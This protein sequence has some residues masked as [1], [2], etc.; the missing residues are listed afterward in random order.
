[1]IPLQPELQVRGQNA[2]KSLGLGIWVR[3]LRHD[4]HLWADQFKEPDTN[5]KSLVS[6]LFFFFMGGGVGV[7]FFISFNPSFSA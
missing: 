4:L 6:R 1:M 2:I 5:K 3:R 7:D